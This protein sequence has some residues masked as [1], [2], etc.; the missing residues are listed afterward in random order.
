MDSVHGGKVECLLVISLI[1]ILG[2][3]PK[4][5]QSKTWFKPSMWSNLLPR[6]DHVDKGNNMRRDST[7]SPCSSGGC[8][9]RQAVAIVSLS[10]C[11]PNGCSRSLVFDNN[12]K[13]EVTYELI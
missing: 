2:V 9:N 1:V 5:S 12:K 4:H 8:D 11:N 3:S 6:N 13:K 10:F 7:E